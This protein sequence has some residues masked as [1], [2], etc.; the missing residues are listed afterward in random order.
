MIYAIKFK[1]LCDIEPSFKK[2]EG[3]VIATS[4]LELFNDIVT[5][6]DSKGYNLVQNPQ[7]KAISSVDGQA[8][9]LIEK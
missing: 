9:F 3:V 7:G 8:V 6:C 4:Y 5:W 2:Y 1:E